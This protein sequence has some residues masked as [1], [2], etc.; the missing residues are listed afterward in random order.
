MFS[1]AAFA[2]IRRQLTYK[3][4]WY[5]GELV[6][7]DRFYPSSKTCSTC[8]KVNDSLSL[9]DRIFRCGCGHEQDRDLNA[10]INLR[11]GVPRSLDVEAGALAAGQPTAK[12][13][14]VKRQ[15]NTV[16]NR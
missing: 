4:Q 3:C 9:S 7:H 11:P 13:R 10:A 6:V 14:P 2:E 1:D 5:G 16:K 12:L 15:P 8:G